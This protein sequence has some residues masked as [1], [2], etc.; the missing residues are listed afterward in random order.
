MDLL[1]KNMSEIGEKSF[2]NERD[3]V[4]V[5]LILGASVYEKIELLAERHNVDINKA[6]SEFINV[7]SEIIVALKDDNT[8][9]L[10]CR[11]DGTEEPFIFSSLSQKEDKNGEDDERGYKII[12][13]KITKEQKLA[14]DY[15]AVE[16]NQEPGELFYSFIE[17][18][19][20]VGDPDEILVFREKGEE[21]KIITLFEY[22]DC[23]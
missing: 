15:L 13:F 10:S 5:C 1:L 20:I 11:R 22:G 12:P 21:D 16:N 6:F 8:K 23:Y 7:A 19:L 14:L 4:D 17:F 18:G 3:M 2:K 9:M